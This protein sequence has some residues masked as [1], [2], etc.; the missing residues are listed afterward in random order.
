[1]ESVGAGLA[2]LADQGAGPLGVPVAVGL[3]VL[4]VAE[5]AP[6]ESAP[7]LGRLGCLTRGTV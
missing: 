2:F 7:L 1:M 6:V 4:L 3:A 5:Y